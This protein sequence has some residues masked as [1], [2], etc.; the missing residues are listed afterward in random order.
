MPLLR[1]CSLSV[2]VALPLV[3]GPVLAQPLPADYSAVRGLGFTAHVQPLLAERDVFGFGSAEA[4]AWDALFESEAGATIVPF[5]AERSDLVRFVEDLDASTAIPYPNLRTLRPD[6]LAFLKRWIEAGARDDDG[7]VPYADAEHVL[8]ACVQGENLVALIDAARRR[9]IRRVYLDDHGLGSVPYGPHH[10]VF[11]DD[12]SAWYVSLISA[13]VVAKLSTDLS[14]DPSDPA[15]LL[16][17]SASGGF[18]RLAMPDWRH[19]LA[20]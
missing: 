9:V 20:T 7:T 4:Y 8:F 12:E 19:R 18:A 13:G 3:A 11:E 2:L 15:Y 16:A 5:D 10:I 14:L 17:A 1:L 6:E